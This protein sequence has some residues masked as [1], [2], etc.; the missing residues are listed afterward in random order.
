M[1]HKTDF[2]NLLNKITETKY[3]PPIQKIVPVTN[4]PIGEKKDKV[5]VRVYVKDWLDLIRFKN[6][7]ILELQ[8]L[9]YTL[10]DVISYGL[11]LLEKE[12]KIERGKQTI[13]LKRGKR[14]LD[15]NPQIK[16]TS[17]EL[18][19]GKIDF[20]NDF[21]WYRVFEQ[22]NVDYFRIEFF[23]EL[24]DIIKKNNKSIFKNKE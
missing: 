1:A 17:V 10:A 15:D 19:K 21:F 23:R 4:P 13:N 5:N 3:T 2:K 24:T 20:I 11:E 7:K 6:H 22:G 14:I 12:Y 8:D 18:P 16:S 9:S